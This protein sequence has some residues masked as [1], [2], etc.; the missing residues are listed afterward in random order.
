MPPAIDEIPHPQNF[1]FHNRPTGFLRA[2]IRARQKHLTNRQQL[3][4]TRFMARAF[5]LIVK[6]RHGNLHMDARTIAGFAI[7][8]HGTPV[9]YSLQGVDSLFN[10]LPAGPPINRHDQTN[11]TRRMFVVVLVKAIL[12]HPCATRFFSGNPFSVKFGHGS[13]LSRGEMRNAF[14]FGHCLC[15]FGDRE[16]L[17]LVV[18]VVLPTGHKAT[19]VIQIA[20]RH[21]R[22]RH[23]VGLV[24]DV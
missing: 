9:P 17:R 2:K 11:A 13:V 6:E 19:C 1:G 22:V 7:R 24:V 20:Q 18:D 5:D 14:G 16:T 8:I 4:Q 10:N 3:I 12:G 15:L 23:G 21:S